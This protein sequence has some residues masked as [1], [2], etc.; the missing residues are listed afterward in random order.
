M[1]DA[2]NIIVGNNPVVAIFKN[3]N[4]KTFFIVEDGYFQQSF[5]KGNY[6]NYNINN[7]EIPFF[8]NDNNAKKDVY[9]GSG[10]ENKR[11]IYLKRIE[12]ANRWIK[13]TIDLIEKKDS[14]GIIIIVADHGGWV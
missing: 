4:Y 14:S 1:Q 9:E 10:V 2:R 13:K 12:I 3:N 5:Q 11:N 6:D 8:S 7:S